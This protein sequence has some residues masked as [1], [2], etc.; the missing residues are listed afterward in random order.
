MSRIAYD[1]DSAAEQVSESTKTLRRAIQSTDPS[2]Y[3]PPLK[4]K[5]KGTAKNA[6]YAILHADLMA[7]A[8]SLPDA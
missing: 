2:S 3:P 6:A 7:W 1:L 4:A 8:E 5:R